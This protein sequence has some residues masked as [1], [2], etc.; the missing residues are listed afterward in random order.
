[1]VY[2]KDEFIHLINEAEKVAAE[3]RRR[4]KAQFTFGDLL[5]P[6]AREQLLALRKQLANN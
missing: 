4:R 1:M 5:K 3:N 2:H 6:E